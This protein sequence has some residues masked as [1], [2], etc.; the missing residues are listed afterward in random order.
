MSLHMRDDPKLAIGVFDLCPL[1]K[2]P[3]CLQDSSRLPED[4][5]IPPRLIARNATHVVVVFNSEGLDSHEKILR[6]NDVR[7][8]NVS[9]S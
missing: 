7:G 6:E 8:L 9:F 3:V 1:T 5:A 4:Y 2:E